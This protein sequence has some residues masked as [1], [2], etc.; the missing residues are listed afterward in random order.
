MSKVRAFKVK[1]GIH[2]HSDGKVYGEGQTAGSVVHS[3]TD[4]VERFP[5]K[6]E[7]ITAKEGA[8]SNDANVAPAPELAK[9]EPAPN[10]AAD[11]I[12]EDVT[13]KFPTAATS[14]VLVFKVE[15]GFSV[16]EIDKPT[17]ALNKEPIKKEKD[18][19]AFIDEV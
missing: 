9:K 2:H 19:I 11:T 15:G 16:A 10:P 8:K 13:D 7:E 6:F 14:G 5:L 4:L 3:R 12:G 17:V 1:T 18:V